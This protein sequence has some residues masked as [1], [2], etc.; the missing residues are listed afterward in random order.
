[1]KNYRK[2][3]GRGST[4]NQIKKN[5]SKRIGNYIIVPRGGIRL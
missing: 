5:G 1:M 4:I 2:K 3:G